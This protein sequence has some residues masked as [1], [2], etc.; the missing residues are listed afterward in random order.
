MFDVI[1]VGGGPAGLTA[2]NYCLRAGKKVLLIERLVLGGQVAF[3]PIIKNYPAF[4]SI[5]GIELA[6]NMANQVK[7]NNCDI[8]YSDVISYDLLGDIKKV[9]TNQGTFLART[10]ILCLGVSLKEQQIKNEKEFLGKGVS[11][12]A[13]CDGN[14]FKGKTVV[15]S[16]TENGLEDILY[17]SNIV[18]KVVIISRKNDFC[19]ESL[20]SQQVAK[21]D[22]V[23]VISNSEIVALSG[24]K[25]LESVEIRNLQTKQSKKILAQGMFVL[26]GKKPDTNLIKNVVNTDENGYIITDENMQ[27]NIEG[28]FA[29]GDVRKK[30]LKQIVTACSDGAIASVAVNE[31]LSRRWNN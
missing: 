10:I 3:T 19:G 31:Y 12:C 29:C 17:L 20:A 5:T 11:Y 28:V 14:F 8:V 26:L 30:S 18:S 13:T 27:T 16:A 24:D 6:E 7:E 21:L 2:A 9:E 23:E 25:V 22:N 15:V 1:V 4:A